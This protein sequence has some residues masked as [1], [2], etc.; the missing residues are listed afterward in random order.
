M[1]SKTISQLSLAIEEFFR[2]AG[3]ERE[4]FQGKLINDWS[5]IVGKLIADNSKIVKFE[6]TILTIKTN[7]SVWKNELYYRKNEII[8]MINK[9]YK[10]KLVSD[11]KLI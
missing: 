2:K 9:K 8:D 10:M 1:S 5:N 6:G 3:Y 11:I 4:F 7:S